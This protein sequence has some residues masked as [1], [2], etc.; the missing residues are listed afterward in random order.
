[1]QNEHFI[2]VLMKLHEDASNLHNQ[3]TEKHRFVMILAEIRNN[4]SISG[5]FR[6]E[7]D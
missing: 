5:H 7:I 4:L 6:L 2:E 3:S 1:M